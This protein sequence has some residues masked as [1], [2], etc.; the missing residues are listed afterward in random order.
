MLLGIGG[1]VCLAGSANVA[2]AEATAAAVVVE[3]PAAEKQ[4]AG[5]LSPE[6]RVPSPPKTGAGDRG[7]DPTADVADA[8]AGVADTG[9]D[10]PEGKTRIRSSRLDAPS[11]LG[12][13]CNIPCHSHTPSPV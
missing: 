4:D 13:V 12:Y 11:V 9:S 5:T 10:R 8:D 7:D 6:P 1:G 2:P 3:V